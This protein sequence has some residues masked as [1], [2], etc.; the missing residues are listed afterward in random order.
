MSDTCITVKQAPA[1]H[2]I[3]LKYRE[4]FSLS[5]EIGLCP[6]MEGEL[7]LND[8]IILYTKPSLIKEEENIILSKK[9]ERDVCLDFLLKPFLK[10]CRIKLGFL[11]VNLSDS[12]YF[13]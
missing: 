13:S 8:K 12:L 1:L 4:A 3:Q 5:D 11:I 6:N 10:N 2:T 9:W 7:E